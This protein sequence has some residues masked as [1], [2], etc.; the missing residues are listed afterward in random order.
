MKCLEEETLIKKY[1][2]SNFFV[3]FLISF[4]YKRGK[5]AQKVP[6]E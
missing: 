3:F 2:E 1:I 4:S 5:A 6:S